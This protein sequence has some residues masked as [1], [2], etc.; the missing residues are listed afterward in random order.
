MHFHKLA[1]RGCPVGSTKP[2][3]LV[4]PSQSIAISVTPA[5]A[6]VSMVTA[7]MN[8]QKATGPEPLQTAPVN[9]QTAGKV[10]GSGLPLSRRAGEPPHSQMLGNLSAVPIKVPQVSSLTRLAVQAPTVLP[11]VRPKTL[12]P[13][14]LP[15]SPSQEQQATRP[16]SL[17]R[18]TA[19][20]SPR[21]QS[22]APPSS[23]STASPPA[24]L[25]NGRAEP[26]PL[27]PPGVPTSVSGA[28][29][30][31]AIISASPAG[32]VSVS[33]VSEAVKVQPLLLSAD[34]KVIIIQPQVPSSSQNSPEPQA[35]P[36]VQETAPALSPP[37]K[38][39]KD[40]DPEKITFMVAL[41][42]VTTEHLEEI[43]SKRQER[44]RR[45]T[46]NPAYSGLF[47]PERKRNYLNSPLFLSARDTEDLGWKEEHDEHCAVCKGDGDLQ[48]CHNCTRAYHLDCLQPPLSAPP[49]GTW[50]CPKCQKKV[51]NKDNMPWPQNVVQ[52]YVT[53]K[54]VRLEEKRKLRK[55][56]S[57]L[58]KEYAL[59]DD[60]EQRLS[61]T[62]AKCMDL[63]N[64]LLGQQKE[65]QASLE[66]L[67]SLIRLI[68]RDQVIQVTMTA[69]TTGASLLSL[70]WIKPTSTALPAGSPALL[71]KSLPQT[72]G[73][74]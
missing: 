38:K 59:L 49:K 22:L 56:N 35:S 16:P 21:T 74:N 44:K 34:S 47:E 31:Y 43:Q 55:R 15:H 12:I 67:K 73:N 10:A 20:V 53:H 33:A 23:N 25:P 45:S 39:K 50:L 42:L 28:G 58:K 13:D 60:Q 24:Q 14:S 2:L 5:K 71:Q 40:E 64:S 61:Q 9:L 72:Q 41:G 62:L 52:S 26:P 3:S 7:H 6:A 69:T 46:A 54:T 36:P 32:P 70:P 66:R 51:L 30:A 1:V 65:T 68:Q 57:E 37:A 19:V 8:G 4:K 29:V 18:A 48:P 11:Q 17:Q 63:K 27:P